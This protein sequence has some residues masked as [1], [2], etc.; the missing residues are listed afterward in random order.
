[1]SEEIKANSV[2]T[3]QEAQELLKISPS[4]MKRFLKKG[5]IKA[6]KI[7]RQ[8]RILGKELLRIVSPEAEKQAI[9]SY[10]AIKKQVVDKL[11]QW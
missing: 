9:R 10:L 5:L 1:M 6:N 2:Y 3:P 11:N 7:G 4:T 8:Y